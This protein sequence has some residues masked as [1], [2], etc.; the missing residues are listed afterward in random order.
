[1]RM[2][3]APVAGANYTSDT[4]NYPWHRPPDITDYDEAV[5][6]LIN[7]LKDPDQHELV[8][9]LM[10]LDFTIT[11]IVST[12]LMQGIAKGKFPID[13]AIIIAGPLARYI[14]I[15]ADG[16]GVKYD[17]GLGDDE[18][19]KITPTSLKI[20]LGVVDDEEKPELTEEDIAPTE[21]GLMSRGPVEDIEAASAD[22]QS[23]ML[24]EALEE[25][26]PADGLA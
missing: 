5:G 17:M 24:G 16:E 12:I 7:K 4:R 25:E 10:D 19:M 18:R 14:S 22:E 9:S 13:L 1:M 26:E 8:F 23:A 2:F 11:T 6:Y 21:G 3:S 20:A 15:I